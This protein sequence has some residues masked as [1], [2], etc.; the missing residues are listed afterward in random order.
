MGPVLAKQFASP[1]A[2]FMSSGA[3]TTK[4]VVLSRSMH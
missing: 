2:A 4:Q 1:E 3:A